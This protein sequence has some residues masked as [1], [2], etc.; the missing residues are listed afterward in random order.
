MIYA[1]IYF[2]FQISNFK[3]WVIPI[4][5]VQIAVTNEVKYMLVQP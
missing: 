1:R 2:K 5:N 4:A 3:F